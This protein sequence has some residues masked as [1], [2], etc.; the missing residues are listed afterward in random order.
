MDIRTRRAYDEMAD[1]D[2]YRVLVDRIWPRGISKEDLALDDW[3]K[4]VAP[5][6]DLRKWFDHDPSKWDEFQQ[7][8]FDE[9]DGCDA[10]ADLAKRAR[11][12]RVTLIFG[13]KDE[14][15]NNAEALRDWL[16]KKA[17]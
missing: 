11:D 16:R 6:D 7:R 10:A 15:H 13:A 3:I 12:G 2:G 8:Y 17:G 5:S 1:N 4:E 9:L 14:T